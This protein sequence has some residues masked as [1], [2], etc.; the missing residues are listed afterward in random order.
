[1][2]GEAE[3][4]RA[5]HVTGWTAHNPRHALSMLRFGTNPAAT[6]YDS[7]GPRFFLALDDGWLNLGLWEGNGGAPA[8]GPAAVRRRGR[9]R[10]SELPTRGDVLD[11]GNGLGA[12]DV[13]IAEA[14][15]ARSLTGLNIA[16]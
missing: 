15:E 7:I 6:V 5:R 12:Q 1:M 16:L 2:R 10:A 8:E 4:D 3:V 13:V 11:V 14:T 9:G